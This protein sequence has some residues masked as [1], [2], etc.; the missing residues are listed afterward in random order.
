MYVLVFCFEKIVALPV[1]SL[2][3]C[4]FGQHRALF[5]LELFHNLQ[6]C[7]FREKKSKHCKRF[8][9]PSTPSLRLRGNLFLPRLP[10]VSYPTYALSRVAEPN[11]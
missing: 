4:Y 5:Y 1:F 9:S 6:S 2:W 3:W 10:P 7:S 11:H 8:S